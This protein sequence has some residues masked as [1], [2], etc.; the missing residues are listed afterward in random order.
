LAVIIVQYLANIHRF[1]GSLYSD[2]LMEHQPPKK[3]KELARTKNK[4]L[5]YFWL[6]LSRCHS[7]HAALSRFVA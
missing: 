2:R 6:Q 5:D 3:M 4:M 7:L 1:F